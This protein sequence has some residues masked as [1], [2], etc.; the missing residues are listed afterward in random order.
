LFVLMRSTEPGCFRTCSWSFWKVPEEQ[1]CI[2]FVSW[3][4]T[5]GVEV[6]AY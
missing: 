4:W 3:F 5:C 1:G 2:R 6:L